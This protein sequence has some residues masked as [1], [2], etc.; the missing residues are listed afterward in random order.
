MAVLVDKYLDGMITEDIYN[1]KYND[2]KVK[3]EAF[4]VELQE[5]KLQAEEHQS[6]AVTEEEKVEMLDNVRA[7][8]EA[9]V[10]ITKGKFDETA[11]QS[12]VPALIA[13]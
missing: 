6:H 1:E 12:L 4:E 3:I 5:A 8:L 7:Q 10:E 13:V 11:I 2:L 9:M